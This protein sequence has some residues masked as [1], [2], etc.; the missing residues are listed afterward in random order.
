MYRNNK[1]VEYK[2]N[3]LN[4][5]PVL[6]VAKKHGFNGNYIVPYNLEYYL[7]DNFVW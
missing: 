2:G 1:M 5:I 6:I 7:M 4:L 3:E